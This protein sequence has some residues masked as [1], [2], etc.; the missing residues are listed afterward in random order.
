V[1]ILGLFY[2]TLK[3]ITAIWYS[4]WPFDYLIVIWYIFPLFGI[5]TKTYP[6]LLL[7]E[8]REIWQPWFIFQMVGSSIGAGYQCWGDTDPFEYNTEQEQ[9]Y[10]M[11]CF[12]TKN[13]QFG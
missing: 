6:F 5:C 9:G 7:F 1:E 13:H 4:L 8:S 10:Q 2:E 11:V 3:Y 12:Q